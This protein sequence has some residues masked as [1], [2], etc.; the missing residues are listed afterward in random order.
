[1]TSDLKIDVLAYVRTDHG[2]VTTMHDAAPSLIHSHRAPM[3][4]P[5]SNAEQVSS[6]RLANPGEEDAEVKIAGA[7]RRRGFSGE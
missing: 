7:G 4:N 1:M 3:F 5:G 6:L 2:F